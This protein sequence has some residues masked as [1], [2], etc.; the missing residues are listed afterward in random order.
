VIKLHLRT[1]HSRIVVVVAVAV[2]VAAVVVVVV[3]EQEYTAFFQIETLKGC[4][5]FMQ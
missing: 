2:A 4:A 1:V 3:I 5:D